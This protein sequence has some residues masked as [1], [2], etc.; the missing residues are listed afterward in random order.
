MNRSM[1]ALG[2]VL[3]TQSLAQAQSP[4]APQYDRFGNQVY[5]ELPTP[6]GQVPPPRPVMPIGP[7]P[8]A[9]QPAARVSAQD[10][11][12]V[13][14]SQAP[15]RSGIRAGFEQAY[16]KAGAPRMA[17]YFNRELSDEVREWVPED[18]VTTVRTRTEHDQ[19][20]VDAGKR[21]K[22]DAE[23]TSTIENTATT[24]TQSAVGLTGYRDD[25][26][27]AWKWEFEDT[28]TNEFL[29]TRA[30]LVDRSVIFRLMAKHSPQT[31]GVGGSLSTNL[32]EMSALEKYADV[33]VE[34]L[35][36]ESPGSVTG[37]DFRATAKQIKTGR[38]VGTAYVRGSESL[39]SPDVRYVAGPS[40][41]TK[42][43]TR[44]LP[45]V[46]DVSSL[47][48]TRLMQSMTGGL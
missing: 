9:V 7:E 2:L 34:V 23:S 19:L 21:G 28:V 47:L 31:A 18:A 45:T 4:A 14:R 15:D 8:T 39:Y 26:R 20:R 25:P 46:A 27:E 43:V 41:Y 30:N 29:V 38:L 3:G 37:Y 33:L 35:V 22:L 16:R 5:L 40:G 36:T 17:V 24:R 48:A 13:S 42:Q 1:L 10:R 32:N 11:L 44:Q 6:P 12:V